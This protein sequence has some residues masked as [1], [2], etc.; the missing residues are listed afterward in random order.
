M[1]DI[2]DPNGC[3][4]HELTNG[5][6]VLWQHDDKHPIARATSVWRSNGKIMGHIKFPPPGTSEM[7]DEALRLIKAGVVDSLSIGF[8]PH[9]A[10]Q[11]QG[12]GGARFLDWSL[13]EISFVSVPANP[14]AVVTAKRHGSEPSGLAYWRARLDS[15][16]A[17]PD[18]RAYERQ[19]AAEREALRK[20]AERLRDKAE[21]ED[22]CIEA[23]IAHDR[24]FGR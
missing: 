11:I 2:V 3:R 23:R 8:Q 17:H 6:V 4:L 20:R 15:L 18:Y 7:S 10:E 14:A 5:L 12:T 22:L 19:R 16:K 13:L 1:R 21:T 9:K 24:L